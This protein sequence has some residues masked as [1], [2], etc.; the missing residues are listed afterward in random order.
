MKTK[1]ILI[2]FLTASLSFGQNE[3]ITVT[4]KDGTVLKVKRYSSKAK[5]L[6][7]VFENKENFKLPYNQLDKVEYEIQN[8]KETQK[9]TEQYVKTSER[10]GSMMRLITSG[11]CNL[12][13]NL[14]STHYYGSVGGSPGAVTSYYAKR[15]NEPIATKLGNN[16]VINFV[17]FKS[18]AL[19]Y[20][21]DCPSTVKKIKKKFKRKKT[22][23][24]VEFYNANCS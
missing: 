12:Y 18:K 8:K 7:L 23:E 21:Q 10:N 2:L 13:K 1:I 20:F 9:I 16:S 3:S 17:G 19:E 5:Y 22:K 6:K 11:K 24:L 15:E 4:K 14:S